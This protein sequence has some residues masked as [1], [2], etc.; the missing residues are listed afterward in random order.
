VGFGV[1]VGVGACVEVGI[2]VFES[3][4]DGVTVFVCPAAVEPQEASTIMS[5]T[6]QHKTALLLLCATL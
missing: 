4:S 2:G 1:G 3:V 5:K 6:T